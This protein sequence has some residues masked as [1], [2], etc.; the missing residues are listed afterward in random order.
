MNGTTYKPKNVVALSMYMSMP[1]FG[2]IVSILTTD[3]SECYFICELLQTVSFNTHLHAYEVERQKF[4]IPI[5]VCRHQD[6]ADPHVL[7]IYHI[8]NL[9]LITLK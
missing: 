9:K 8:S 3:V 6:F 4:P 7:A 5:I 1:V 2:E